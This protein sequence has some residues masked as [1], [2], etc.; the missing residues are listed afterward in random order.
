MQLSRPFLPQK[1]KSPPVRKVSFKKA[2]NL[3]IGNNNLFYNVGDV[4]TVIQ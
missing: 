2:M 1:I 3:G 4:F